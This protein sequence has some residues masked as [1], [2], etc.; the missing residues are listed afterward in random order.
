MEWRGSY[1]HIYCVTVV[2]PLFEE[3][4]NITPRCH[5][6]NFTF[7]FHFCNQSVNQSRPII[8]V[9]IKEMTTIGASSIFTLSPAIANR[10]KDT[11]NTSIALPHA[12]SLFLNTFPPHTRYAP[13]TNLLDQHRDR[14]LIT[15][16][17]DALTIHYVSIYHHNIAGVIHHRLDVRVIWKLRVIPNALVIKVNLVFAE[18]HFRFAHNQSFLSMPGRCSLRA[19]SITPTIALRSKSF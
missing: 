6:Q 19:F 7:L 12:D 18:Q 16:A 2:K 15:G 14:N 4:A 5:I 17:S 9:T 13:A 1:Y 10:L 11:Q 8:I 3:D